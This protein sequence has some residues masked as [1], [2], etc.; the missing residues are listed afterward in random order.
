[1]VFAR[2]LYREYEEDSVADNAAALGFYFVFALFPFLFFLATL[3]AYVPQVQASATGLIERLR[4]FVPP[5]AMGII[6]AHVHGLV[7][8]P[9]PRLLTLGLAVTIYSAS[10]G[11]DGVRKALNLAYDV[12]ETRPFWKTELI[13]LGVTV[14]GAL[15]V[16]VGVGLLI[17]GGDAGLWLAQHLRF[18]GVYLRALNLLRWLR[19]P[20]TA[21][22]IV[23]SAALTYGMLPN[24]QDRR[25][26]R[27][28]TPGSILAT[29]AWFL[30][31]WGFTVYAAHFGTYNVTYGSIGGVI[32]LL[33]WFY[34]T[35]FILLMGGEIDAT[36]D[37][38]RAGRP[39]HRRSREHDAR[40][41]A[42]RSDP[43]APAPA[44]K[45]WT[46]V[47]NR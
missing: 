28:I 42:P 9:R 13:A 47:P 40:S 6:E 5:Q 44:V 12:K 26:F 41:R 38:M 11:V 37:D 32:V 29:V 10:R 35:S 46:G 45:D 43:R 19:W 18:T 17:I 31:T 22:A 15:L 27:L 3:A 8:T 24:V 25:R 21:L 30:G 2:R 39:E 1:V 33:T 36:L 23:T 4:A 16:L 14:G 20:A 34:L 7:S